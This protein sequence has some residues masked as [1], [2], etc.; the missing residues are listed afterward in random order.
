M[1]VDVRSL[2]PDEVLK[3]QVC[4]VGAGPVGLTI[5]REFANQNFQVYILES[6]GVEYHEATQS[7]SDGI[8]IGDPYPA[9]Y[10]ES[11]TQYC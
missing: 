8:V 3:T 1:I 4:I 10:S 2:P 5:A 7:L 11:L 6:G 9:E